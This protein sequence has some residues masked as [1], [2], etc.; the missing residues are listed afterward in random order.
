MVQIIGLISLYQLN[1]IIHDAAI[2]SII[3]E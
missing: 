2:I 3:V 1:R